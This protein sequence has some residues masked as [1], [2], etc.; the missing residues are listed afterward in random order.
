[1]PVATSAVPHGRQS[2]VAQLP[3][4]GAGASGARR[5]R[6]A[7]ASILRS[8]RCSRWSTIRDGAGGADGAAAHARA[9]RAGG[10]LDGRR[11][12]PP[13]PPTNTGIVPI[14]PIMAA[15]K[16]PQPMY[17]P[18]RDLSQ[19]LLLPGLETVEPNS[20]LGL[21]TNSRFV[22]AYMVGLNVEMGRELLWRG[23]PDRSARHV[24]RPLL[25]SRA[26][27]GGRG[28]HADSR[29]GSD[30]A[31]RRSA[32]RAGGRSLRDADAQ[33]AAAPL[34]DRGDLRGEGGQAER[35]AQADASRPTT[36]SIR[37]SAARCSRT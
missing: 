11:Q 12:R 33:R 6:V 32:D 8:R 14:E 24:L 29:A 25:G 17:E 10:H 2:D 9:A 23:Y 21:K 16:F 30:R 7:S 28:R 1:M 4:G 37:C 34:S 27:G 36:R 26:S 15:P 19:E 3:H 22:E 5:I 18:L 31:A 35:R 13:T 20:V